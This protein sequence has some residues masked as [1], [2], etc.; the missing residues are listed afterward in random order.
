MSIRKK[1]VVV[2]QL[3]G[4]GKKHF[5]MDA[6]RKV[7]NTTIGETTYYWGNSGLP[8]Q[9]ENFINKATAEAF[10][11]EIS[12]HVQYVTYCQVEEIYVLQPFKNQG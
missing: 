4:E 8:F 3:D 2:S 7:E 10:L 11:L 6:G 5:I 12:N 1:M 9:A